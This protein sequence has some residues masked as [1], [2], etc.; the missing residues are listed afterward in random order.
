MDTESQCTRCAIAEERLTKALWLVVIL[1]LCDAF[2][3]WY[4][5]STGAATEA[6]PVMNLALSAGAEY[7]FVYKLGWVTMACLFL[8]MVRREPLAQQAFKLPT[9]LYGAVGAL[10]IFGAGLT[11]GLGM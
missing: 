9:A 3:T 4:W 1:N 7:F 8:W 10:H 2:A 5:V 6:N 11:A